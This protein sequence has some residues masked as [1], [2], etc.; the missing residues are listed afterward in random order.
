MINHYNCL[1]VL[2][3]K[4]ILATSFRKVFKFKVNFNEQGLIAQPGSERLPLNGGRA[5]SR[6]GV[7]IPLGPFL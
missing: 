3:L 4:L 1:I 5:S 7:R 6:S 2:D